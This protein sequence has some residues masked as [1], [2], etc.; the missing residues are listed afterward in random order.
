MTLITDEDNRREGWYLKI[1]NTQ[2][3][4]VAS[5][6]LSN[7]RDPVVVSTSGSVTEMQG[8]VVKTL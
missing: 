6:L 2:L 4:K 7:R 5:P 8:V 3:M 1:S